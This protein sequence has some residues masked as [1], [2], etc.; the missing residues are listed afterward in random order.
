[1][2]SGDV[3]VRCVSEPFRANG[4]GI[5]DDDDVHDRNLFRIAGLSGFFCSG[6]AAPGCTTRGTSSLPSE[7]G[8]ILRRELM[9]SQTKPYDPHPDLECPIC[10]GSGQVAD[11]PKGS[12]DGPSYSSCAQCK[13]TGKLSY[14]VWKEF[15]G[16][17]K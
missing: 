1:L 16:G 10:K 17:G 7:H 4:L 2:Q 6:Q 3:H 15:F 9:M 11:A 12:C 8:H 14:A 13:G 5:A